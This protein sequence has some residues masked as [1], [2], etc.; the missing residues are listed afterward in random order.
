MTNNKRENSTKR[1]NS[2]KGGNSTKGAVPL[3]KAYYTFNEALAIVRAHSLNCSAAYLLYCGGMGKIRFFIP[4]APDMKLAVVGHDGTCYRSYTP[5]PEF[6]TLEK[7]HCAEIERFNSTKQSV[8][9][10]GCSFNQEKYQETPAYYNSVGNYS[11]TGRWQI[12]SENILPNESFKEG[13]ASINTT[14]ENIEKAEIPNSSIRE[15]DIEACNLFVSSHELMLLENQIKSELRH[16]L[17][18]TTNLKDF[19]SNQF[20]KDIEAAEDP[21]VESLYEKTLR[22]DAERVKDFDIPRRERFFLSPQIYYSL[23]RAV[24]VVK[25]KHPECT[26][27]HLLEFGARDKIH[28][29]TPLPI[30]VT[31]QKFRRTIDLE[32]QM[33]PIDPLP[34]KFFVL[35]SSDCKAIANDGKLCQKIFE[36]QHSYGFGT[37]HSDHASDNWRTI[38]TGGVLLEDLL[39]QG[40]S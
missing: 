16:T 27:Q 22:L 6:L 28:I 19:W 25:Q 20:I 26:T 10:S 3:L 17:S 37:S 23:T 12:W 36:R 34:P 2:P 9:P 31:T 11:S 5:L 15:I 32:E 38:N 33:E 35:S 40:P 7:K 29:I 14:R 30:G 1:V 39:Q 13:E 8:F 21:E 18:I 24:E 4:V